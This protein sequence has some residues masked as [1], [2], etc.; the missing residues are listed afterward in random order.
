MGRKKLIWQ[1]FPSYVLVLLIS[2]A[3]VTWYASASWRRFYLEQT[4]KDLEM[5][6]CLAVVSMQ[7]RLTAGTTPTDSLCKELGKLTATRL[8]LIL[9]DGQVAGDSEEDP[10]R[11]ENHGDR[12]EFQDALKGRVGVS[13]RFS[14]TL[15]Q[16]MMYVAVPVKEENQVVGVMRAALP[17]TAIARAL[18]SLYLKIALGALVIVL[19]VAALS[20][21][22]SRRISRPLD[23]LTRGARRFAQ[24]DLS[25]KLPVPDSEEL[26]SLA[27]AM[28]HMAAQLEDRIRTLTS[29][30]QEQEAILASMVEGVLALNTEGRVITLNQAGAR[31]L[32]VSP[33]AA[34]NLSLREVV[35]DRELLWFVQ[36]TRSSGEP[37]EGEVELKDDRERVLQIHGTS[38]RDADGRVMGTLLVFHDITT[39]KQLENT[40]R[41]FVANVSHELKTPITAIKGFVETL[42]AGALKEPENA[43]NFLRII[44][45]H[46][47]RLNEIIDDLLSLSRIEQDAERRQIVLTAQRIK[48]VLQAAVQICEAKAAAKGILLELTCPE[49]LRASI[50]APLLEQALVN[51]IDNAVKFSPTGSAVAVEAER[52]GTE[53]AIRVKDQGIGIPK[54]HLPRIFERF[55]RVDPG[56][57]RKIGGTGLGLA[58]VKHI[59]QAHGGRVAVQSTPGQGSAFS[60]I[61]PQA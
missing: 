42:L 46:T 13:T 52:V 11:M 29:Q 40:R 28:N 45:Q 35:K 8:T 1:L 54:E 44:A 32:G 57:S 15:R 30:R 50:N 61:L 7:E 20:W 5:R 4:A 21:M 55:Y 38:L 34:A 60:L 33:Q 41:D 59:A 24:G 22:I 19:L 43:D 27:E 10:A 12:P 53:I 36:R 48:G 25:R 51:L 39:L 47:D 17:L 3:A 6:A 9:P 23:D 58:I 14:F 37:V 2:V 26:G 49:E 16:D 18:K 31:L 56:R